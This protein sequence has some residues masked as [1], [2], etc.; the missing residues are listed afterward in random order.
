MPRHA[1]LRA[2]GATLGRGVTTAVPVLLLASGI[3]FALGA[4]GGQDPAAAVVG[5]VAGPEDVAR[6]ERELGLDRPVWQQYVSWVGAAARG[7]LGASWFTQIP[8]TESIAQRLPVSLSVAGFALVLAVLFG[9]AAGIAAALHR[10]RLLDR[11]VTAVSAALTTVPAFVAGIGLIIVFAVLVPVLPAGGYVPPSVS[12]TAWLT[13]LVLPA[14]ALSLDTAADVARQ[15]RTGLVSA[16][17]ENYVVG[18]RV[19]GLS[20]RRVVLGHV[21]RNGVAP[22]VAVVGLHVPRLVGGAV[23]TEAVFQMPGLGQLARDAAMRGDVPVVQGTLLVAVVVVLAS[24]L[25]VDVVQARLL[26]ASVRAA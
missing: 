12:V 25:V 21:L 23:I 6:M 2:V 22:A 17:G 9:G 15:L 5:D 7:D 20:G 11:A 1:A 18:A 16:L 10:G 14:V 3:T 13:S 8:V 4:F 26:P 24:S 19:R